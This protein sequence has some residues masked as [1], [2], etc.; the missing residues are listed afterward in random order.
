VSDPNGR[1]RTV[2]TDIIERK[3]TNLMRLS[4]R[5]GDGVIEGSDFEIWIDRLAATRG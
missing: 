2:A 5:N 1:S 3:L 4:D